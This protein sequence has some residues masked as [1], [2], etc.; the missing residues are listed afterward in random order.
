MVNY[1][2]FDLSNVIGNAME[3]AVNSY[4]VLSGSQDTVDRVFR[5]YLDDKI[6]MAWRLMQADPFVYR[7]HKEAV[8]GWALAALEDVRKSAHCQWVRRRITD[9]ICQEVGW[10]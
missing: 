4:H 3:A 7:S 1:L 6:G 8:E 10:A 9:L 2:K 5:V